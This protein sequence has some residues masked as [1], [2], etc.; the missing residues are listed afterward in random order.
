MGPAVRFIFC[1]RKAEQKDAAAIRA[2]TRKNN[3]YGNTNNIIPY[4][5]ER[6]VFDV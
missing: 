1:P 6:C 3:N 5:F 4:H 2:R